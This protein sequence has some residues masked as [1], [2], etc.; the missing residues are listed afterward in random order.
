M[1]KILATSV[2]ILSF[3]LAVNFVLAEDNSGIVAST[4]SSSVSSGVS[5]ESLKQT[6]IK[7]EYLKA[8]DEF[9]KAK[10]ETILNKAKEMAKKMIDQMKNQLDSMKEKV[11]S[12]SDL[13]E[14]DKNTI[15]GK[16]NNKIANLELLKTKIDAAQ[17]KEDLRSIVKE[18][19]NELKTVKAYVKHFTGKLLVHRLEKIISSIESKITLADKKIVDLKSAGKDVSA[20]EKLSVDTKDSLAKAKEKYQAAKDKYGETIDTENFEKIAK[21]ASVLAREANQQIIAAY[22]SLKDLISGINKINKLIIPNLKIESRENN[23]E[24]SAA[25]TDLQK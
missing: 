7:N 15:I 12:T 9:F 16:I 18:I 8:R 3:L 6:E 22:K 24:K 13:N 25:S 21:E 23:S 1:K 17:T 20:L 14:N 19:R 2:F 5:A 11:N 4:D 10:K